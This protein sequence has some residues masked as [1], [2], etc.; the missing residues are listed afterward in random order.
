M[1][2]RTTE[3]KEIVV[4]GECRNY[5]SNV[6]SALRAEKL[7]QKGCEAFL[8]YISDTE[9]KDPTV[10]KL[11]TVRE[12]PDVL[13]EELPRLPPNREVEYGI[14]MLPGTAP[15]SITPYR[16]AS[17]ELVELK[18]QIQELLDQGFIR[19]SALRV[20][21]DAIRANERT[22]RFHRSH[23]SS[24]STL[25]GSM[26]KQQE[27]FEKLKK[28]LTK[29]PVLIQPVSGKEFTVYSD[30]SHD[31]DCMIK[32]HTG[33]ANVVA[34]ALSRMVKS[35]LRAM[36]ARLSFLDDGSLL[37][38]L[39]IKSMSVEQ[40]RSKQ[41]MDETLGARFRQ[42]ESEETSDF[43]MNSEG[44]LCFHGRMCIPKDDNLRQS[45]LWE[46]HSD[47]YTM[48][49]SRNKMY[50][51]LCELYWW[52]RLKCEVM[53]F[54]SKC[55]VC[56]KVKAEHQLPLGL[57]QPV[58]PRKKVLR[59]GWKGKLSASFFGPYRVVRRIGPVAYQL[60]L[61]PELS[62]IHDVFHVT[63]LRRY[64]LDPSHVV[65]IEEIEVRLDLTFKEEPIQII[66]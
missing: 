3:D 17:K 32:Y 22:C 10:G 62:Q 51:N 11:R 8:A 47:L 44:V 48:Y 19:P 52:P 13:P 28:V 43:G 53:E 24:L 12:F 5:L 34:D 18:A 42:V 1:V 6:I 61:L 27:S 56:Q 40:I 38:E 66:G 55:L 60:E 15:M 30:A 37:A 33:K 39:Q 36:L 59:F 29:A 9:A 7:V 26:N 57:F 25:L 4:I 21:G 58:S 31:Y 23:E 65:A 54:V 14:E 41:L 49:P 45:I 2:L 46:A 50:Q 16:M 63:M 35:D 20:L 64:H